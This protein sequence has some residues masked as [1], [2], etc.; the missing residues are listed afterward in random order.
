MNKTY[1]YAA[2]D[3][4]SKLAP[5]E[6]QRRDLRENDVQIEVLF[7]GVCHSDLHQARNEWSNT[8]YPVVPG[9]EIVGRV[10]AV[11]PQV[12]DAS[13]SFLINLGPPQYMVLAGPP[14]IR[15]VFDDIWFSGISEIPIDTEAPH[16]NVLLGVA[17]G[18]SG[19]AALLPGPQ[20]EIANRT[21]PL[22]DLF[23]RDA[24]HLRD[25]LLETQG[26]S[27]RLAIVEEWLLA[28]C[29]SGRHI[30][31]LVDWATIRAS[32]VT[33]TSRARAAD[34]MT[35][36]DAPSFT[37]GAL[38]AVTV[39]S[40]LN[41]GFNEASDATVV[42]ARIDSSRSKT[43]GAPL[44]CGM[45]IGRISSLNRPSSVAAAAFA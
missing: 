27:E 44:F 15:V 21:G 24:L 28:T 43:S 17:F 11:G 8:V 22:A 25:C 18:A 13:A 6:F 29:V 12:W 40:L 38:P 34:M 20:A 30:H 35:S 39:P 23:G 37:G 36:A 16:G 4:Q 45:P 41:A 7:C 9:H 3:A 26:A 5:F 31:P 42:S 19:A 10:A 32:G 33:P 2:A 14:E 1:A